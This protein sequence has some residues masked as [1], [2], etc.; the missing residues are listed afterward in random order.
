MALV[1]L[2]AYEQLQF[3]RFRVYPGREEKTGLVVKIANFGFFGFLIVTLSAASV[4]IG[5]MASLV[6]RRSKL[7]DQIVVNSRHDWN[8]SFL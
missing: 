4:S 8:F 5:I 3:L 2:S 6:F 1:R 7:D